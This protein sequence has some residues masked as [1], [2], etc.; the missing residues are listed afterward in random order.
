M[1][2][3]HQFSTSKENKQPRPLGHAHP[4][5]EVQKWWKIFA[6]QSSRRKTNELRKNIFTVANVRS[7][8]R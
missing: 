8:I 3:V 4:A 1:Q 7:A 6:L 5:N 2:S